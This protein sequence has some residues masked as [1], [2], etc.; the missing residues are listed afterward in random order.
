MKPIKKLT[1]HSIYTL[2]IIASLNLT[3]QATGK[4]EGLNGPP[5]EVTGELT[6]IIS[7]DFE[8]HRSEKRYMLEDKR[9]NRRFELKFEGE[10][11]ANLRSGSKIK[12]HGNQKDKEI[13]LAVGGDGSIEILAAAATMVTGEQKTL[14]MVANFQD[15]DVSCPT[16]DIKNLMFT[17][18]SGNSIDDLFQE[19]SHGK[20]WLT[21]QVAGT[22]T[23]NSKSTDSCNVNTWATAM[24]QFAL[25]DG[26]NPN[27]YDRKI[28]VLPSDNNCNNTGL[29]SVGDIPS[30]AWIFRCDTPAVYGHEFGHNLGMNHASTETNEYGDSTDIL[31]SAL[32]GLRQLNGPHQEQMGWRSPDKFVT[33][34]QSGTFYIAPLELTAAET[35]KPQVLKITKP[36]SDDYYYLSYRQPIGFDANLN[37]TL[38]KR[39]HIHLYKGNGGRTTFI[40]APLEGASYVDAVNGI[41]LTHV[42]STTE[43]LAVE[44]LFDGSSPAP[45]C[46]PASPLVNMS[47]ADQST[48]AG[49]TLSYSLTVTNQDNSACANSTFTLDNNI[50]TSWT[51][52]LSSTSLNLAP[53]QTGTSTFSVTSDRNATSSS[54]NVNLSINDAGE[55]THTA[56]AS[57]SYTVIQSCIVN[58]PSLTLSPNSQSGD[59]GTTLSYTATLVNN[60]TAA[61]SAS[62]FN[63]AITSLPSNLSGSLSSTTLSLSPGVSVSSTLS[64]NSNASAVS[65]SYSVQIA[66]SDNT[67]NQHSKTTTATYL[68]NDTTPTTDT[69]AP[70]APTSLT[71]SS[72][73]KQVSLSWVTSS[74]NVKVTGYRVYR[75]GSKIA[76]VVDTSY[77]D[78]TGADNVMYAY[79]VKAT[80]AAGNSSSDSNT[81]EAGK[82]KTKGK[83]GSGGT[84]GNSKKS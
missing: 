58:T 82:S 69:E 61:C 10:P 57:A 73:F 18:P 32:S 16:Q 5:V 71:A 7:D 23:L 59:A 35:D 47:P 13:Y 8:N 12:V 83:G 6:V 4:P 66:V 44:A 78:T 29:A 20:I 52:T 60:D 76:D 36:G 62:T 43:F 3:A 54:Y 56:S 65:G 11:P 55:T 14:V 68:V 34:T 15:K 28:Y 84:K 46:V 70:T 38:T 81:A 67:E 50:P 49:D 31:G 51:G 74:D 25:D 40:S 75:D 19:T 77:T 21:G 64:V 37:T 30:Q 48:N 17:D 2:L 22:Y 27:D 1:Q 42:T 9:N 63:M 24:D 53:G 79:T 80:D 39:L 26:I 41:T 72:N 33:V 45:T